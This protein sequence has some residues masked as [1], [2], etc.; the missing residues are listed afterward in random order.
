MPSVMTL[1]GRG[2]PM[3]PVE[4]T[5]SCSADTPS[6]SAAMAH[7]ASASALPWAPVAALAFPLDTMTPEAMPPLAARWARLTWT[8]AAAA[9]LV[10]KVAAVGTATP[11][12]VAT[13]ARSSAPEA[14]MPAARPA[15]T[16]PLGVV[17]P[18]DGAVDGDVG[19]VV[20]G[21]PPRSGGRPLRAAPGIGW[22]TGWP[23]RQP[24]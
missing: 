17:M 1:M 6:P 19:V 18:L 9:R 15:A 10:V 24:P 22:R 4:H 23:G 12:S 16:N 5:S 20:M 13:R 21:R 8:G 3:S 7:M 2:M 14:L 11:S